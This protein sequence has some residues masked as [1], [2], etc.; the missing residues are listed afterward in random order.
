MNSLSSTSCSV[1]SAVPSG[2]LGRSG[3]AELRARH[4]NFFER[5]GDGLLRLAEGVV[6]IAVRR[7]QQLAGLCFRRLDD[8]VGAA[9]GFLID[10]LLVDHLRGLI[11]GAAAD[12]VRLLLG[13]GRRIRRAR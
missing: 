5:R 2:L 11:L 1:T 10:A 6:Q 3:G 7:A 9:L 4:A 8:L 13:V 12:V